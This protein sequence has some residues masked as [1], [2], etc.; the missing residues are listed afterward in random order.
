MKSIQGDNVDAKDAAIAAKKYFEDTK[1]LIK[2][3]FETISVKK[4]GENWV[5]IC[6]VQDLFEEEGKKFKVIVDDGGEILD[7]EKID[8]STH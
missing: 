4:E 6:L 5:V 3:I 8:Q 1:S 2:F 7:V